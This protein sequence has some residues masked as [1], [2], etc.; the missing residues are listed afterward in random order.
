VYI[1]PGF[2]TLFPYIFAEDA[3]PYLTFL[4]EGLGGE[5]AGVHKSPDG[6][7][8]NALVRFGDT[9]IMVS[10]AAEWREPSHLTCYLYVEDADA[11]LARAV[12]AGGKSL[13][14]VREMPYGERQGG[15]EDPRGNIWWLSQRLAPGP[16]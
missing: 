8:R 15:V 4:A 14:P 13:N 3:E 6:I 9:T 12:A 16:Y 1:P 10:E 2:T 11:A 5:I 7:V